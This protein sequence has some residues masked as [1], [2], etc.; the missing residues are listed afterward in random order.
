MSTFKDWL[1]DLQV[2]KIN[3]DAEISCSEVIYDSRKAA[4]GAVFVCLEGLRA[5]GHDFV[6]E[7]YDKGVRAFVV[8][9][10]VDLPSDAV[11]AEVPDTRKA[12]SLIS[13]ARFE[14]AFSKMISIGV[15]GTKGKTTVTTMIRHMLEA[16]GIKT[17]L[18]GTTGSYIGQ[19]RYPTMNT[20]PESYELQSLFAE[21]V[22]DGCKAVV[23]ECSSQGIK[24]DRVWG[25]TF[26]YG[27]F[28]NLSNDHIGPGEHESFDE[29]LYCKSRVIA[30]SKR[31]I[32]NIDD[33]HSGQIIK[34]AEL[35]LKDVTTTGIKAEADQSCS[36]ITYIS[37]GGFT[38]TGFLAKGLFQGIVE[39]PLAG[40]FNVENTL[41]VLALSSLLKLD[42]E[43][44]LQGI[45]STKV[46]GRMEVVVRNDDYTVFVDYAHN[47]VSMVSL[48]ETLRKNYA[49]KR[50]VVVFGCGGNRSKDRR[51]SMGKAAAQN[52]D[53]TII[54]SDNPRFEKPEDI[55]QDIV[56]SFRAAGGKE[57]A[58][59]GIPSRQEAIRYA[60]EH[61]RTG[62]M[63]AVIGKGHEDYIEQNGV[64]T[65]FL[66]S[67]VILEENDKI[68]SRQTVD[69]NRN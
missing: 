14:H 46:N 51:I 4:P 44:T 27:I 17:G 58:Y 66:D 29:Y 12:L 55:I 28:L 30:G 36:D 26:D 31:S 32:I 13:A 54:T 61:A 67:E 34:A 33:P 21:M 10:P 9:R 39:V 23:M 40:Y 15:T 52:A 62:D 42:P 8:Q 20:T 22:Q 19:K 18:I 24:Q 48:L 64:R 57:N 60:L 7:V 63:I 59:I 65:H 2:K 56:D 25:L 45:R 11:I 53:F 37:N 69:E 43:K 68:K 50:L 41:P 5:D 38:G 16:N 47:E 49:P 1:K 6:K 35:D 3:S